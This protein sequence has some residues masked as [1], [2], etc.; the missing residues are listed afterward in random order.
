M[1]GDPCCQAGRFPPDVVDHDRNERP[2]QLLDF[3]PPC[4]VS[5]HL[6]ATRMALVFGSHAQLWPHEVDA[7]PL[8]VSTVDLVLQDG[9]R[10]AVVDHH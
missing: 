9:R 3:S 2:T 5:K 4:F 1:A 10:Q 8:A 6:V 7:P